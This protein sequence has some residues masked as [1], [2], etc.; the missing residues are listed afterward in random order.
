MGLESSG[1]VKC[2][3]SVVPCRVQSSSAADVQRV[4][5]W[6]RVAGPRRVVQSN[7]TQQRQQQKLPS[8]RPA[9]VGRQR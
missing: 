4:D 8:G 5:R 7:G 2:G 6:L 3:S 9:Q 1:T